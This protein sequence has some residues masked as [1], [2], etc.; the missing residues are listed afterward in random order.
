M[1][2]S[3]IDHIDQHRHLNKT[4]FEVTAHWQHWS[5][6]STSYPA[7]MYRNQRVSSIV[8]NPQMRS[9]LSFR[10]DQEFSSQVPL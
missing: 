3:W 10:A 8:F 7:L 2:V 6:L 1:P 4:A 9:P 5:S